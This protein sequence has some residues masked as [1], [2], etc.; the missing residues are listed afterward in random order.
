MDTLLSHEAMG[1][2]LWMPVNSGSHGKD[3][4]P[5]LVNPDYIHTF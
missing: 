3:N 5:N 4:M 1:E 2:D